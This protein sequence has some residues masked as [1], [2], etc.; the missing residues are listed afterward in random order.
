MVVATLCV[1]SGGEAGNSS[2]ANTL[3]QYL[4]VYNYE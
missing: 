4:K 3:T 1:E 2:I